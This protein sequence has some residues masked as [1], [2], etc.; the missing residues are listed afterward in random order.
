HQGLNA[1]EQTSAIGHAAYTKFAERLQRELM[2]NS[3]LGLD[4]LVD[5]TAAFAKALNAELQAGRDRLLEL[6][7]CR[8]HEAQQVI[9]AL[10]KR[11]EQSA[12]P[13]Y[14]MRV[15]DSFNVEYERHSENSWVLHPGEHMRVDPF[16]GLPESG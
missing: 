16:P 1:F 12:L 6:N 9:D 2:A 5:E 8:P 13:A 10:V 3:H 7:A 4:T 14:L 15:L 11:D